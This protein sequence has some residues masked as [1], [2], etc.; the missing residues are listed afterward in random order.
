MYVVIYRKFLRVALSRVAG[1]EGTAQELTKWEKRPMF[2]GLP[3]LTMKHQRSMIHEF[4][5]WIVA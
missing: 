5:V 3:L 4:I 2:T 1:L